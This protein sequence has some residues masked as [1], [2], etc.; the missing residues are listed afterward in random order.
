MTSHILL[1][2]AGFTRNWGAWL[3]KELEGDLLGRLAPHPNLQLL[4]QNSS[5]FEEALEI[6]RSDGTS[7]SRDQVRTLEAT[8]K[9]SF[10]AMNCELA[11]RKSLEFIAE[12]YSVAGFLAM[13]DAIFTLNQDLLLEF[14]YFATGLSSSDWIGSYYPGLEPACVPNTYPAELYRH[15]KRQVGSSIVSDPKRQPIYKLHGSVD[16]TD[17]SGDLFVV[18]GGKEFYIQSK[19]LLVHYFHILREHLEKPDTRLMVIGYGW[20]D[21]HVNR[22][23]FDAAKNNASLGI[24]HVHPEGRDAI[25]RGRNEPIASYPAPT[26]ARLKCIGESRRW[27]SSTFGGDELER[28][29]LIRFFEQWSEWKG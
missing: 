3:A 8:I 25:P 12:S 5:N 29:K 18:G 28:N 11:G 1:T 22:L 17:D 21:D 9:A 23:I 16:W 26:L 14:H 27:L 13:F 4:I 15:L 20:G 7:M 2:G 10:D 24:F 6:A 19:P